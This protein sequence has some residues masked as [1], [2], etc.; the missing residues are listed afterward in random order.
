MQT[1]LRLK[2]FLQAKFAIYTKSFQKLGHGKGLRSQNLKTLLEG[3]F[4]CNIGWYTGFLPFLVKIIVEKYMSPIACR[5]LQFTHL[6]NET[7]TK[8][9]LQAKFS[10]YI[11]T[12]Q[13]LGHGKGL[14][15]QNLKT[16]LECA[17]KCNIGWYTGFLAI[18][19]QNNSR[20]IHLTYCS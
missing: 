13:K 12:C 9:F 2:L 8:L 14:R 7:K 15:S 1:K 10:I 11:D 20:K 5:N 6:A 4:K 18:F 19:G 17:L 3:T 16:L